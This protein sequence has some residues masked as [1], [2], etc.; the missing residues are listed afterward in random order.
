MPDVPMISREKVVDE[1][2]IVDHIMYRLFHFGYRYTPEEP[3]NDEESVL[4]EL[5]M[6]ME[7]DLILNCHGYPLLPEVQRE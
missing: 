7:N 1:K 2:R 5:E 3:T 6:R 4:M